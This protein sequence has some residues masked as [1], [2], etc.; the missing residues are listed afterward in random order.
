ARSK[1]AS[2][3]TVGTLGVGDLIEGRF[4][5]LDVIGQGGFS[6]VYRV[7]DRIEGQPRAL[8]LINQ[9]RGYDYVKREIKALRQVRHRNVV[10]VFWADTTSTG[11]WYLITEYL[12]GESLS[13][14]SYGA[15]HLPDDAALDIV[16]DILAALTAI[17]PDT[18]RIEALE[19][20]RRTRSLSD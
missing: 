16:L 4:E 6:R 9:G 17:H 5:V 10:E 1:I 8:K 19:A 11:E 18:E 13:E 3:A 2:N 20:K 15:R 14:F 12:D 7:W